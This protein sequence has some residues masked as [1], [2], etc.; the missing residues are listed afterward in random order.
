M[1]IVFKNLNGHFL[2]FN[3]TRQTKRIAFYSLFVSCV[4]IIPS[5]SFAG[6]IVVGKTSLKVGD[7]SSIVFPGNLNVAEGASV[8]NNGEV[9]FSNLNNAELNLGSLLD[10]TGLYSIQ[11]RADITVTGVGFSSL[12]VNSGKSVLVDS[13]LRIIGRLT[14]ANGIVDVSTGKKLKI[15]SQDKEAIVFNNSYS[16]QSFIQGIL[17]RNTSPGVSYTFPVGTTFSGFHPFSVDGLVSSDYISVS[18][19]SDFDDKWNSLYEATKGVRLANAGG[20]QLVAENLGTTFHPY[21]S[22][23]SS[24]GIMD[25]DYLLFYSANPDVDP[26]KFTLDNNSKLTGNMVTSKSEAYLSGVFALNA[27]KTVV[28][29]DGVK[30]PTLVNFIV[31]DGTGRTTFE[32]PAIENYKQVVLRV[33]NRFGSKVYESSN[34]ANDFDAR[35]F[36]KGTYFYELTLITKEEKRVLVRNIIEVSRHD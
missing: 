27:L 15:L 3:I 28:N 32:V 34:Y 4:F 26:V 22:L 14:L 25:G 2:W 30:I 12:D 18:Y 16:N 7:G 24:N 35:R 13:D 6:D 23:F 9:Y 33:Y 19:L 11:G 17:S 10:G 29:T 8:V 31:A 36:P 1:R 20:W 21:L 5:V